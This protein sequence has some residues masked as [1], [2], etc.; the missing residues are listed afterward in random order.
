M[1]PDAARRLCEFLAS[2]LVLWKVDARIDPLP[3]PGVACVRTSSHDRIVLER[4]P[5]G[6]PFRWYLRRVSAAAGE[7]AP[8]RPCGSLVGVLSGLRRML[9]VD[10]S[11]TARIARD[12]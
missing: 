8:A 12:P 4:A 6:D 9:G 1:A 3:P 10:T 5:P 11:A 2:T 7:G